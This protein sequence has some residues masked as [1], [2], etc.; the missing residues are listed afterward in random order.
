MHPTNVSQLI[1]D[2]PCAWYVGVSSGC[3]LDTI[4]FLFNIALILLVLAFV[5]TLCV[6]FIDERMHIFED[7][8]DIW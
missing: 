5:L 8:P 3:G 1:T 4:L 7:R 2:S 6:A